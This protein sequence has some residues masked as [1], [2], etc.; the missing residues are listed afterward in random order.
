MSRLQDKVAL[1]IGGSGGIGG[2]IAKGFAA[3]GAK[4]AIV[5]RTRE[6][7]D[8]AVASLK[9][10]G[11]QV[12]GQVAELTGATSCKAAIDFAVGAFGRLDI[13]VNSQGTTVLK[14]IV[15][16]TEE[17]Y[18]R[19]LATNLKSV[20]F[21]CQAAYPRL[22]ETRGSIINIASLS[23]HRGWT[24]ASPYA[25]SKHG[26]MALTKSFATEWAP[27]GIRVN[28]ITPGFFKTALNRA[29]S[30]A[31]EASAIAGTPAGRFGQLEELVGTAIFLAS[32][33][34]RFI[35]GVDIP[36]DGGFLARGI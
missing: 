25:A 20:F 27:D 36:V 30:P 17:E 10:S 31:R 21:V 11:A 14:P 22:C 35:T 3:E 32:E 5:G 29:M 24:L 12:A 7:V 34:A 19:I 1:V 6:K 4:L 8:A 9:K 13:L 2:E 33:D 16:V 18:D 15:E 26:V 23:A 28:S